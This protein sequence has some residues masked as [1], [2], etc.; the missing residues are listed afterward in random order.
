MEAIIEIKVLSST[1][2]RPEPHG[3]N[4]SG[5]QT[6]SRI[7]S[8]V[9]AL[10]AS[11]DHEAAC[12]RFESLVDRHQG[13]ATRIAYYYLKDLADV[14]EAV[15]DAFVKAFLHLSTFR[16]ELFFELWLTR[17]LINGCI[18]RLKARRRRA[19]WIVPFAEN[20][21]DRVE[22]VVSSD[23][24]PEGT[25]LTAERCEML[26]SEIARLPERQR[27]VVVLGQIEGHTTREVAQILGL[28]DATVRVH[29]FRA[30]RTLRGRL[31]RNLFV[32]P[33]F[34][35]FATR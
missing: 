8:E 17:I 4:T 20:D 3:L 7:T 15:Q 9:K 5:S 18:D 11:G 26:R 28:N 24:S 16:E 33:V 10:L 30:I 2:L 31:P 1:D 27:S 32:T 6:D 13:R 25:V 14:D 34:Q 29:L 12:E 35:E 22:R 21:D 19:Q 23:P